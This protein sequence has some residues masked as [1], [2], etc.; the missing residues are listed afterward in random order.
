LLEVNCPCAPCISLT[1]APA[2]RQQGIYFYI[3]M[4]LTTPKL[5][6]GTLNMVNHTQQNNKP[7]V[8]GLFV[9]LG[10]T[11]RCCY[12]TVDS[13]TT[14]SQ[15]G[16]SLFGVFLNRACPLTVLFFNGWKHKTI[17]F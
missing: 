17:K 3:Q 6:S 4:T 1:P 16:A 11:D 12:I 14:T 5:L 10:M 7:W 9:L 15:N 13:A 2:S 8:S